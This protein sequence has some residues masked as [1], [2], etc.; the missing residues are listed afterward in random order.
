[1]YNNIMNQM[2]YEDQGAQTIRSEGQSKTDKI[3]TMNT[4][5]NTP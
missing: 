4:Q 3:I 1:M 2:K 5:M